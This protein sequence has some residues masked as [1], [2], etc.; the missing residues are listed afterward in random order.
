MTPKEI[1]SKH[2]IG[3]K[4]IRI[5]LARIIVESILIELKEEGYCFAEANSAGQLPPEKRQQ[6]TKGENYDR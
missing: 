2:I 3:I 4:G 5:P 1:I 6:I